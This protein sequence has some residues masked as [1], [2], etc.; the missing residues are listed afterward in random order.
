MDVPN[1]GFW[2]EAWGWIVKNLVVIISFLASAVIA[3]ARDIATKRPLTGMQRMWLFAMRFSFGILGWLVC[4]GL[5]YGMGDWRVP[6][7]IVASS[8]GGEDVMLWF[9][10]KENRDK[11][12]TWILN[13]FK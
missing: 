5:D 2:E 7:I 9:A 3:H 13:R 6:I 4:K 1:N 10:V 8:V 12:F 11:V